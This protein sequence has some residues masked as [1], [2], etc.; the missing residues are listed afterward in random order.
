MNST[1]GPSL[2]GETPESVRA[3]RIILT[4]V[5]IFL[6]LFLLL[7]LIAIFANALSEGLRVYFAA[8]WNPDARS[9]LLLTL[10]ATG[11]AVPLNTAFGMAAAWAVSRFR[12]PGRNVLLTLI[13][14]P[15]SISPVIAGLIFVLLLGA[16]GWWGPWLTAHGISVIFAV[17]GILLA[18]T[19]V[20]VPYVARELIPLMQAQGTEEEEAAHVLGAN[21]WQMF[22]RVTLPKIKWGLLYGVVLSSARAVGE[23]GAVSVVSGHIRGRTNTVPL[24][25]EVLYDDYQFA[26]AFAV[27][28]LLVVGALLSLVVKAWLAGRFR[29][30]NEKETT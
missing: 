24:H 11:V 27:A 14:L 2:H 1:V 19:F 16:H 22:W 10:L 17:P 12:F 23:F 28:S 15:F 6:G 13:D 3:R 18:T 4:L 25:I 7:P 21:G 20:T 9:A 29:Q 8:L 30:G 26:A 5:F